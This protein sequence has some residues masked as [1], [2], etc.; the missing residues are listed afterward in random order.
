MSQDESN[1]SNMVHST[2]LRNSSS[3]MSSVQR[4]PEP[5]TILPAE[6]KRILSHVEINKVLNHDNYEALPGAKDVR[7]I[8]EE[9]N[10][11]DE[12]SFRV[13]FGDFHEEMV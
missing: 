11:D 9:T 10:F 2:L 4:S 1:S 5:K 6:R 12:I 13:Q 8:L 7:G 3:R